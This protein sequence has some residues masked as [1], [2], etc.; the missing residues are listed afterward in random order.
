[1]PKEHLNNH[2]D[3]SQNEVFLN[4]PTITGIVFPDGTLIPNIK[5]CEAMR[6]DNSI[7]GTL[8]N[9]HEFLSPDICQQIFDKINSLTPTNP[10]IKTEFIVYS[11]DQQEHIIGSTLA[12]TFDQNG[13]LEFAI[14]TSKD[15]TEIKKEQEKLKNEAFI[16][17]L[18]NLYNHRYF[19]EQLKIFGQSGNII[20]LTAIAL[21]L[22]NL[23]TINNEEGHYVGDQILKEVGI[24]IKKVIEAAD[25][26]ARTGG[27]EFIILF[28]NLVSPEAIQEVLNRLQT[29]LMEHNLHVSFGFATKIKDE[30]YGN[31]SLFDE[32]VK[33]ADKNLRYAKSNYKGTF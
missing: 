1:M 25:V 12:G 18:T 7:A 28:P 9:L 20:G 31:P 16:D 15:I 17:S 30:K 26:A 29:S 6:L 8:I 13:Q 11:P 24:A 10:E 14:G 23:R 32:T 22:D 19:E 33:E 2:Q 5:L 3:Q 4:H 21:D 27:D